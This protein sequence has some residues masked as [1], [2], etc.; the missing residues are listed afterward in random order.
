MQS[1]ILFNEIYEEVKKAHYILVVTAQ[2]STVDTICCSLSLSNFF[3]ENKIKHKVF[4]P[5]SFSWLL[6]R[7]KF[8]NKFDKITQNLPQ[9]YD[10]IIFVGS[11][12]SDK[13]GNYFNKEIKSIVIDNNNKSSISESFYNF[14]KVNKLHLSKKNAECLYTGIYEES[15][16][17]TSHKTSKD[18]FLILSE[19]MEFKIDVSYIN[20]RLLKRD[21]LARV[22]L[23]N[24]IMNSLDLFLEGKIAI[25]H[26]ENH[27]LKQTGASRDECDDVLDK[28]LSLGV[29]EI[30]AYVCIIENQAR[31]SFQ[32]KDFI[33]FSKLI[34]V[35]DID[36]NNNTA[37]ISID[38]K[39]ISIA[40][41]QVVQIITNYIL[42]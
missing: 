38:T 37:L 13:M 9:F 28:V 3:Y 23:L 20:N 25:V 24:K 14:Y 17:F 8:L 21:S 11:E 42:S 1:D 33:D 41:E 18:T 32:S 16:A 15:K 12:N 26:L 22:R 4:N 19:L 30:A 36:K 31:V 10:L 5:S 39:D 2:N 7:L 29:V 6:K 34:H 35:F 40:K 27:W